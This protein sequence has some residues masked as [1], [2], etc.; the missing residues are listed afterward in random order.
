MPETPSSGGSQTAAS[1]GSAVH[2][3]SLAAGGQALGL[4]IADAASPL[5][6]LAS[7]D[8]DVQDG[9]LFSKSDP[10]KGETYAALIA[11]QNLP[12]IEA[13]TK[14]AP[15]EERQ[16]Y[17]MHSFG[18]IFAEVHVDPDLGEIRVTR[19]VGAY[20]VGNILNAKTARS[21]LIGG[22][23]FGVSMALMEQTVAERARAGSSTR[24]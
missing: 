17:A 6:G 7:T 23:V 11:R 9:R 15:G 2:D 19:L 18:A 3:A 22:I 24:T 5:H 4:I 8:V 10:T 14:S 21:Q 20:G 1:T 12:M 13:E 16:Q